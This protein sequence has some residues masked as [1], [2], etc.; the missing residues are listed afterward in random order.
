MLLHLVHIIL[1]KSQFLVYRYP[2][3]GFHD[4]GKGPSFVPLK[5]ESAYP[6]EDISVRIVRREAI[7]T[8]PQVLGRS[9]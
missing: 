9:R 4:C 3:K 2:E 5:K 7:L 6:S 1:T 8:I